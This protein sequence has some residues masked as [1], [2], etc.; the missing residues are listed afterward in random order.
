MVFFK[1]VLNTFFFKLAQK[2]ANLSYE[3]PGSVYHV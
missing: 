3:S 2:E 1:Q